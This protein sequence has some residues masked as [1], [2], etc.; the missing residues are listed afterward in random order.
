MDNNTKKGLEYFEKKDYEKAINFFQKS[1]ELH[2]GDFWT[3][4]NIATSYYNLEDYN[5]AIEFYL[6]TLN[7]NQKA[8]DVYMNLANAYKA[9]GDLLS[10]FEIL[11]IGLEKN[12]ENIDMRHLKAIFLYE[13]MQYDLAIDELEKVLDKD[14]FDLDSNYDIAKIYFDMGLY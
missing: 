5:N 2:G 3:Y 1:I 14:E 7:L 6:K 8:P 10:A 13:D 11:T 9:N 4:N 12:P